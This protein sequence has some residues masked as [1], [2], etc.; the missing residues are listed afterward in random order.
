MFVLD[1]ILQRVPSRRAGD[2]PQDGKAW[3]PSERARV[4]SDWTRVTRIHFL[5]PIIETKNSGD[6]VGEP[7]KPKMFEPKWGAGVLYNE[8][9]SLDQ[10][11]EAYSHKPQAQE[12][13]GIGHAL[14]FRW[15]C[16]KNKIDIW[17]ILQ[18]RDR[19]IILFPMSTKPYCSNPW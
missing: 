6:D 3:G 17:K 18:P 7:F 19:L 1:Y 2:I 4:F 15:Y 14:C 11:D 8:D 5:A 9:A 13:I 10:N 16:P 12:L